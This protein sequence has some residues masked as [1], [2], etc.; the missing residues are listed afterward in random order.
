MWRGIG[1]GNGEESPSVRKS[2]R[3]AGGTSKPCLQIPDTR[4][5]KGGGGAMAV[6]G[7]F[8]PGSHRQGR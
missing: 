3:P 4:F 8:V 7:T 2:T 5:H 6:T 1:A